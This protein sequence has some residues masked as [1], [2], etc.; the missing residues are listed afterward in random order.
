MRVLLHSLTKTWLA[1][2]M[3]LEQIPSTGEAQQI[4]GE[5]GTRRAKL[6]LESTTRVS[7]SYTNTDDAGPAKLAFNWPGN[8][9][10][11]SYDLGG[12]FRGSPYDHQTFAAECKNYDLPRDQ[13][14]HFDKFL[15]QTYCT[16]EKHSRWIEHFLWIT[17]S[18]FRSTSWNELYSE[19]K[20]RTAILLNK[21]RVFGAVTDE[22]ALKRIDDEIVQAVKDSIWLIVLHEKQE[23]LVISKEDRGELMRLQLMREI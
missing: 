8:K 22:E 23:S 16:I 10:P 7:A 11:Y 15:A 19:E 17:W 5:D 20:I 12:I 3:P 6:W 14:K 13:G 4:K 9:Q 21:D 2:E 1:Y 18:P